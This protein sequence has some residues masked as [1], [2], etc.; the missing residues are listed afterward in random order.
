MKRLL[1]FAFAAA[2]AA[3]FTNSAWSQGGQDGG[4]G[5]SGGTGGTGGAGGAGT[6]GTSGTSGTAG[7]AG[8][9]GTTNSTQGAAGAAGSAQFGA[10]Q[11]QFGA[12]LQAEGQFSASNRNFGQ[13][14]RTPWFNDPGVR[15]QLNLN[16]N[17]FNQL[18]RAYQDAYTRYNQGAAGLKN[19]L[20]EQQRMQQLQRLQ[21]RF[22]QDFN[23]SLDTTF[24]DPRLRQRYNQLNWQYQGPMAFNDPLMRQQLNLT[25]DQQQQLRRLGYR[26]HQQL[27]GMR[28]PGGNNPRLTQQQWNAL[29]VQYQ[30]QLGGILSP[31]QQQAYSQLIGQPYDFPVNMYLQS[32]ANAAAQPGLNSPNQQFQRAQRNAPA[33]QPQGAIR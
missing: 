17:Q 1:T 21:A 15:Q 18:S 24:T 31:A 11:N 23:T 19:T 29:R 20:P 25:P 16:D 3:G 26:W 27:G 33:T 9:S 30:N 14:H 13:V 8:A 10:G 12:N 7:T 22:H 4:G 32:D 6:S 28:G 5:T 2:L